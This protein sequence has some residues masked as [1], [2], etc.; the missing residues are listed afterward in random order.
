MSASASGSAYAGSTRYSLPEGIQQDWVQLADGGKIWVE[1]TKSVH[2]MIN[3]GPEGRQACIDVAVNAAYSQGCNWVSN[4]VGSC[5]PHLPCSYG[6]TSSIYSSFFIIK[7]GLDMRIPAYKILYSSFF[8]STTVRDDGRKTMDIGGHH[9]VVLM[10]NSN[11]GGKV[12]KAHVYV[13]GFD[14][15]KKASA[16]PQP[17][18]P[19]TPS[20][21]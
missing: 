3:G 11:Y 10:R 4:L 20:S 17:G 12:E 13:T 2:E 15:L 14:E 16:N 8:H 19:Y 21:N 1:L 5:C 7:E 18:G 9:I 6:T